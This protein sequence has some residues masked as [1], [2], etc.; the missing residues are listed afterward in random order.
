MLVGFWLN[1]H[2]WI[3]L[4]VCNQRLTDSRHG[5]QFPEAA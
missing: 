4:T 2:D 3:E 5:Q 1:L